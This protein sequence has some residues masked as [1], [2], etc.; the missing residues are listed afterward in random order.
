M[1]LCLDAENR[2][3]TK[4]MP[5]L[6]LWPR[7]SP[8]NYNI[9]LK[10]IADDFLKL[11]HGVLFGD[12]L[13]Y[14][15]LYWVVNDLDCKAKY[16]DINLHLGYY[17]CSRCYQRGIYSHKKVRYPYVEE[18]SFRDKESILDDRLNDLET[19][20]IQSN[21]LEKL[22][23]FNPIFS[24][25]IDGMHLFGGNIFS[26]LFKLW[27]IKPKGEFI[28]E[29]Y[30]GDKLEEIYLFTQK[31][32]IPAGKGRDIRNIVD[33]KKWKFEQ[34]N[35]F[36]ST[37]S[38]PILKHYLPE[39]FY[40]HF[41]LLMDAYMILIGKDTTKPKERL[42]FI[43]NLKLTRFVKLHSSEN[44]YGLKNAKMTI[45]LL[46]HITEQVENFGYLPG[47]WMFIF[48]SLQGTLKR[49]IRET[50]FHV[51][52]RMTYVCS[53]ITSIDDI[54]RSLNFEPHSIKE[55]SG[56]LGKLVD[57]EP[58]ISCEGI[59]YSKSGSRCKL[60]K[61][62]YHSFSWKNGNSKT[63]YIETCEG[64]YC[65]IR[66]FIVLD[67]N[68]RLNYIIECTLLTLTG[69]FFLEFPQFIVSN[70]TIYLKQQQL[71]NRM[72]TLKRNGLNYL[73]IVE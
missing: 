71:K 42:L 52:E 68:T 62:L 44:Y 32:S 16:L 17:G 5:L 37:L 13:V 35:N 63:M 61:K 23:Y 33:T 1:N 49:V 72:G 28:P 46:L 25:V 70:Q 41:Q 3:K 18:I 34:W 53:I 54:R 11:F 65:I 58:T 30:I 22:P 64:R 20:Y 4:Y 21:V 2:K 48:E 6:A 57:I 40:L 8:G 26:D 27:F 39:K 55:S 67:D 43:S 66:R 47:H 10:Y 19:G 38:L 60:R 24:N 36:F 14:S 50:T 7:T 51:S 45:H 29:Y 12:D 56:I 9:L 69:S 15:V 31:I 73:V 59:I